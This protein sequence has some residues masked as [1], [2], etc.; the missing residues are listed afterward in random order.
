MVVNNNGL[1][2]HHKDVGLVNEVFNEMILRY[3]QGNISI[4][5]IR[6]AAGCPRGRDNTMP[7]VTKH[8]KGQI[9]FAHN[10]NIV[11]TE[12]LTNSMVKRGA[13]FQTTSDAEVIAH[14]VLSE[15]LKT[16]STER[17]VINAMD[18]LVGAYSLL[19]LGTS[20]LIA[21][22]D[23][24]G[25]RPMCLGKL[26]NATVIASE[27]CAIDAIG[28]E[29]IRDIL[30]GEV[31]VVDKNGIT[32][33]RDKCGK[34]SNLCIFEHI[35]FARTD[36]IIDGASVHFSRKNAGKF[37]AK[38]HPVEA[39]IVAGVPDSGIDAAMGY[40]EESG[41]PYSIALVKN[42]YI[43]RTFIQATQ[44]QRETSVRIKLNPLS[45]V[46]KGKRVVLVDDSIVRGTTSAKL[47]SLLREAGAAE[48]HMRISS[49]PFLYPCYFGTDVDSQ[50]NL[51]A[52]KMTIEEIRKELGADTLGYLST[53]YLGDIAQGS[54]VGFCTAC[55]TGKYTVPVPYDGGEKCAQNV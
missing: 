9:A 19:V 6:Y 25:F 55:F 38:E 15:R 5:H 29:F 2:Y 13:V 40:A 18:Y 48:V 53:K 22:R 16:E 1:L 54:N 39:D 30:P 44:G 50:D 47:V 43:G 28:G 26:G 31:I 35:Y 8:T 14:V 34:P 3:L 37:L 23:P 36:S 32:S 20:K 41:I 11:N 4:C 52:C 45:A 42:R 46:V 33:H 21:A 12:E 17:A 49:P 24:H 10:G 27:S 7:L 51:I